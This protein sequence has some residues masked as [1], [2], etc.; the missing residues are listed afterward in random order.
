MP[1]CTDRSRDYRVVGVLGI[2]GDVVMGLVE[3]VPI[4]ERGH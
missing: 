1:R 3:V 2:A 4:D